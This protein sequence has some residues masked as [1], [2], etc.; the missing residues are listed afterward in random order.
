MRSE[1]SPSAAREALADGQIRAMLADRYGGS[2][3]LEWVMTLLAEAEPPT[4]EQRAV[5]L[6]HFREDP[7]PAP[8]TQGKRRRRPARVAS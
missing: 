3:D 1:L 2:V 6:P 5:I 8:V 7:A 4:E